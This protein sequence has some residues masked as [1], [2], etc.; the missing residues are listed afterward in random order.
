MSVAAADQLVAVNPD[1][2][3]PGWIQPCHVGLKGSDP[4]RV[5]DGVLTGANETG[6]AYIRFDGG[7]PVL[8]WSKPNLGTFTD[9]MVLVNGFLYGILSDGHKVKS[10]D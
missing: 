6:A 3:A 1:D 9:G 8:V 5:G 4:G 7:K 10:P 2:G